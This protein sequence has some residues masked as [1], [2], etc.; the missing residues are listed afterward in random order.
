MSASSSKHKLAIIFKAKLAILKFAE[1]EQ[2]PSLV[3]LKLFTFSILSIH[4]KICQRSLPGAQGPHLA[5]CRAGCCSAALLPCPAESELYCSV[6]WPVWWRIATKASEGTMP[7][8]LKTQAISPSH[9][10]HMRSCFVLGA[11]LHSHS[12]FSLVENGILNGFLNNSKKESKYKTSIFSLLGAWNASTA[13]NWIIICICATT[14][15]GDLAKPGVGYSLFSP[16]FWRVWKIRSESRWR[17]KSD[18][19]WELQTFLWLTVSAELGLVISPS[20]LFSKSGHWTA[21]LGFC[22]NSIATQIL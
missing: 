11:A 17:G 16:L 9:Y 19:G 12:L 10:C 18:W 8:H 5:D 6:W 7:V 22:L 13:Q 14:A 21:Q 1:S 20:W 4:R 3:F 15:A 2:Y